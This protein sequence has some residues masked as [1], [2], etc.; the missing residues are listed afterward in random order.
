MFYRIAHMEPK[1]VIIVFDNDDAGKMMAQQARQGLSK[2][3]VPTL[4]KTLPAWER[5]LMIGYSL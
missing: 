5:I 1:S 3:G 2:Y 4:V